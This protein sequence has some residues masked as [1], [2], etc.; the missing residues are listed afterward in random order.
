MQSEGV[1]PHAG[2]LASYVLT[3]MRAGRWEL[4]LETRQTYNDGNLSRAEK[5]VNKLEHVSRDDA[6]VDGVMANGL[7][8]NGQSPRAL[9]YVL[10]VLEARSKVPGTVL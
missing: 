6:V 2:M 4:A 1:T 5:H 10:G 3:L 7:V 9:K 8:D